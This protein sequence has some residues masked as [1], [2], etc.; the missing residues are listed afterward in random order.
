M[1]RSILVLSLALG[2]ASESLVARFGGRRNHTALYGLRPESRDEL[3]AAVADGRVALA[4]IVS[5]EVAARIP[6]AF[7]SVDAFPACA[8]VIGDI[9]DQSN[10]GCC[11][12]FGAASAASD[13][14]CIATN[15]SIAVPFS[16]QDV[17]FNAQS[18]GCGGGT[19]FTPWSFI[20]SDGVVSGGQYLQDTADPPSDPFDGEGFCASFSL[21]HCHHHGDQGADPYP[22]EGDAGCPSVTVSPRG[23]TACD[24]GAK[25]SDFAADKY[26]FAGEITLFPSD[27]ATIQAA[28]MADGPVEAAFTVYADFEDYAGGVY[29]RG[30]NEPMGGH[31]IRIVGWGA[32]GGLDYWKVANSWNPY[33]GEDGY[34]RIVRGADECGIESQVTASAAGAKWAKK[35]AL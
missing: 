9:R 13:R 3:T 27:A 16:A 8:K 15:G 14:A 7:D 34:F 12:A 20:K 4:P 17:C 6:D 18:N 2:A 21:P 33:W 25:V 24:D 19:L 30:S 29:Q 23:P 32:D 5:A 31:A 28:I 35:S 11:W 26:A 1:A 22:A 10:C